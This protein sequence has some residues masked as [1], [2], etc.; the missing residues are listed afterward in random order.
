MA[1][2]S[3]LSFG[4]AIDELDKRSQDEAERRL[5][6]KRPPWLVPSLA[7]MTGVFVKRYFFQRGARQGVR[8]LFFAVNESMY[9]FLV[10][11]KCWEKKR[12]Q[13]P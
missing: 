2:T 12:A 11:A 10:Y 3:S 13:R 1:D 4:A 8:G 6:A 7:R 5:A 9:E